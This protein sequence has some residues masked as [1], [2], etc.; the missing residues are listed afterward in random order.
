MNSCRD[1]AWPPIRNSYVPCHRFTIRTCCTTDLRFERALPP[2]YVDLLPLLE[3]S[4]VYIPQ[5]SSGGLSLSSDQLYGQLHSFRT[6]KST[7]WADL[8]INVSLI[9]FFSIILP[10]V[11]GKYNPWSFS[12]ATPEIVVLYSSFGLRVSSYLVV[13]VNSDSILK[14]GRTNLSC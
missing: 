14:S 4:I 7:S 2:I 5:I 11:L 12:G 13:S 1:R 3:A 9:G 10:S 6:S 8:S